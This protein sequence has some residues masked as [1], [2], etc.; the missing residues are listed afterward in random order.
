MKQTTKI[1]RYPGLGYKCEAPKQWSFYDLETGG[2]IGMKYPDRHELLADIDRF[3]KERGF[4]SG[5]YVASPEPSPIG[6]EPMNKEQAIEAMLKGKKVTHE[7]FTDNEWMKLNGHFEVEFE[8]GCKIDV[9]T[10]WKDRQGAG[11]ETG[12]SL[13][14]APIGKEV[15]NEDIKCWDCG[16]PAVGGICNC[17]PEIMMKDKQIYFNEALS[18]GRTL[19]Y[20]YD[21][22]VGEEIVNRY[23]QHPTL[24][25]DNARL[26]FQNKEL[27]ELLKWIVNEIET[28]PDELS[29]ALLGLIKIKSNQLLNPNK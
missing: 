28:T 22:K 13:V 19:A 8:D 16:K 9:D 5:E 24:Y 23:N 4:E 6:K 7:Y 17:D 3:A 25:R 12:W 21:E 10:F 20:A 11:W 29:D 14:S 27:K 1:T 15:E 2:S 26:L 18:D